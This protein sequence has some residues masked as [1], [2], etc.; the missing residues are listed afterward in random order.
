MLNQVV[1][2]GRLKEEIEWY[3]DFAV[4]T[5]AVSKPYK[6][7]EGEYDIDIIKCKVSGEMAKNSE[8]HCHKGDIIGIKGRLE[9]S[10]GNVEVIIDKMTF[11]SSRSNSNEENEE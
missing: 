4:V 8:E 7:D 6:N 9:N 1:L 5:L 3:D 11:L 2:V 10:T